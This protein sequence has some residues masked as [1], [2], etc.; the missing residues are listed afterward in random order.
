MRVF[1]RMTTVAD[2]EAEALVLPV[3]GRICVIGGTAAASALKSSF[4]PE[5]RVEEFRA[6]E[7]AARALRSRP[8]G[9]PP[10]TAAL[11]DG[12]SRWSYL[13][14]V[15]ALLHQMNDTAFGEA[16]H[17]RTLHRALVGALSVANGRGGDRWP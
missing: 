11:I 2:V 14:V 12:A 15:A 4:E 9:F 3:D 13:V 16:D 17:A 6:V 5:D 7:D 8:G 10:G 1:V